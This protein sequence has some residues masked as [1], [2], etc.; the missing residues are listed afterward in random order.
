MLYLCKCRH[1]AFL[2]KSS[3]VQT[4]KTLMVLHLEKSHHYEPVYCVSKI[5]LSD[6]IDDFQINHITDVDTI[7]GINT[8]FGH[9][10]FWKALRTNPKNIQTP[11]FSGLGNGELK[12]FL[13]SGGLTP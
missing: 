7:N 11:S 10:G 5:R 8:A 9:R 6:L 12:L 1:C 13:K 3:D 4:V 2:V